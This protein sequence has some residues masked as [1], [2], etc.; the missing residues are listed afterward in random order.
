MRCTGIG[1]GFECWSWRVVAREG[2]GVGMLVGGW[3]CIAKAGGVRTLTSA[4]KIGGGWILLIRGMRRG[5]DG[6]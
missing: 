6:G 2:R 3:R 5:R 4:L 1:C